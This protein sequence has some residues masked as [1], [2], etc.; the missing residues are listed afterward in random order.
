VQLFGYR[1]MALVPAVVVVFSEIA[2]FL[3][4]SNLPLLLLGCPF[5]NSHFPVIFAYIEKMDIIV[6]SIDAV[7]KGIVLA[8]GIISKAANGCSDIISRCVAILDTLVESS[9]SK[10]GLSFNR[11]AKLFK[12]RRG[13][14]RQ[15][16]VIVI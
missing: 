12:G 2:N 10:N 15:G 7:G 1:F 16:F 8:V 5:C 11:E 9:F 14:T 6:D 13:I 4:N 3:W